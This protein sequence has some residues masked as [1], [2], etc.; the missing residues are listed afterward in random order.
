MAS[1]KL[2]LAYGMRQFSGLI[3]VCRFSGLIFVCSQRRSLW[4]AAT[5]LAGTDFRFDICL[6]SGR[7][8]IASCKFFGFWRAPIFRFDICLYS[9]RE[10]IASCERFLFVFL[11]RLVK[12]V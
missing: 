3:F 7:E 12:L 10:L 2:Y 6:G 5:F 11:S 4:Q 9:G 1:C 8:L